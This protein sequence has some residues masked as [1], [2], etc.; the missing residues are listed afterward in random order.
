[1]GSLILFPVMWILGKK[2]PKKR[3]RMAFHVIRWAF[4]VEL[5][6]AG[7]KLEI[8]GKENLPKSGESVLYVANH[9]SYFDMLCAYV[10]VPDITGFVAKIELFKVPILR[11]WMKWI[12]CLCLD[13]DDIRAGLKM[14][15]EGVEKIK[16]G[17]S[18]WISPE[19][20]RS[21]NEDFTELLEFKAGSFK[22]GEKS[23]HPIVPVAISGTR[24]IYELHRPKVRRS[25]VIME[26]GK[27]I[28]TENL[29]R[30]SKKTLPEDTK[31]VIHQMLLAHKKE[32]EAAV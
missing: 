2:A 31:E 12:S 1:M 16:S 23:G 22:L 5:F 20:T 25:H 8:R 17:T 9:R 24:E 21:K 32:R 15:L 7:T 18:I 13:R 3:D 19:G 27:P 26:F 6:L 4:R 10:A 30:E 28:L 14:I 29:D 11:V